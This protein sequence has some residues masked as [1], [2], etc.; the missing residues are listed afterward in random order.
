MHPN[1]EPHQG[2]WWWVDV[3]VPR[4]APWAMM[5]QAVG[6]RADANGVQHHSLARIAGKDEKT[7]KG[8]G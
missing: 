1:G 6:L 3:Q 4:V 8:N 5:W 7:E 2:A